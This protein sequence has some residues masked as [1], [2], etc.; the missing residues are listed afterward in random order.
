MV[1][2]CW[3][4]PS[5]SRYLLTP[6]DSDYERIYRSKEAPF[7]H[8]TFETHFSESFRFNTMLINSPVEPVW[9]NNVQLPENW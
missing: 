4:S 8:S 5:L 9:V 6:T 1:V 2:L 3:M 7:H